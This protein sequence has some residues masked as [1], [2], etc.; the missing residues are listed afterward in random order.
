MSNFR[1]P[2]QRQLVID[3]SGPYGLKR[4]EEAFQILRTESTDGRKIII[5]L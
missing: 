4:I 3:C 1:Y 2:F 5:K